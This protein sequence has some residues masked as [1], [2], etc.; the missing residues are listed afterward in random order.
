MTRWRAGRA[1]LAAAVLA[2]L[3]AM[4]EPV[5]LTAPEVD[6]LLRDRTA[7]GDWNGTPYRQ[8]FDPNGRTV[9][10]PK[11][12]RPDQGKWRVNAKTGAYESWWER[13]G[14]SGYGIAREGETHYWV[15]SSGKRHRF[16]V[17][18]GRKLTF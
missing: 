2:P 10:Q 14:W 12:G 8:Y 11:G 5:T 17:V 3:L 1:A 18:D 7:V 13:S 6:T 4:A 16:T 15:E 9:Y